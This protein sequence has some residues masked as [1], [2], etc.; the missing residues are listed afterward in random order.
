MLILPNLPTLAQF[1]G[2]TC[3]LRTPGG[4][5]MVRNFQSWVALV[6]ATFGPVN[7]AAASDP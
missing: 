4:R 2:T 3:V 6:L 1:P 7:A 5:S